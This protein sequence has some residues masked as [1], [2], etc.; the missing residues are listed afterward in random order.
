MDVNRTLSFQKHELTFKIPGGTSRGV[1]HKKKLWLLSL[2]DNGNIGIGECS[3]IEGLSPDYEND[4]QYEKELTDFVIAFLQVKEP[5]VTLYENLTHFFPKLLK[6][7]SLCFGIEGAILDLLSSTKGVLFDNSFTQGKR[8]IPINGLIWMG[9]IEFMNAQTQRKL[10]EGY[11]VLKYKIGTMD[12]D[13]ELKMLTDLRAR[14]PKEKLTVRVDANGA[15]KRS[16]VFDVIEALRNLDVH[17]IEQP[18]GVSDPLLLAELA[19]LNIV[20]IALDESLIGCSGIESKTKLLETIKPQYII[21]KPS[22]HG[23]IRG[24]QEW[25]QLAE[26]LGIGWWLT[27]ALESNVGLN[28]IA[29]LAGAYSDLLPQG[30]GTGGVFETNFPTNLDLRSGEMWYAIS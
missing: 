20:P 3:I 5:L 27:S 17:S 7:P 24:A 1:M 29:Q 8:S 16:N 19:T 25:I 15:F 30:L 18:S 12:W 2:Q 9:T 22:L 14:F 11:S 6:F 13:A 21:L 28:V 10:D 23:G 4:Q 26:S